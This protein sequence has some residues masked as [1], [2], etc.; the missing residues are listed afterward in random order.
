MDATFGNGNDEDDETLDMS[1]LSL[2]CV[3]YI[4]NYVEIAVMITCFSSRTFGL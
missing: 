4:S 2:L 3:T 1:D